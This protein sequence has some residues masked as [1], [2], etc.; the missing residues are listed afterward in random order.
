MTANRNFYADQQATNTV[1]A[2]GQAASNLKARPNW[3]GHTRGSADID[4]A[5]V[6][7][8]TAQAMV[9]ARYR[10][11]EKGV[12]AHISHLRKEHGL[13][14]SEHGDKYRFAHNNAA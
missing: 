12:E 7:G 6:L 10:L 1:L 14:V 3:L 8:A 2:Q 9:Q 4:A 13:A 11:T 5:L